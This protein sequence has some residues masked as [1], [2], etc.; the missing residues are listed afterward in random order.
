MDG[1]LGQRKAKVDSKRRLVM[2]LE[3]R[4][5]LGA[6]KRVVVA[7]HPDGCLLLF[8]MDYWRQTVR[9]A[10]ERPSFLNDDA[11]AFRRLFLGN[12]GD[13]PLDKVGRLR[14]PDNLLMSAGIKE[15][16]VFVGHGRYIEVWSAERWEE[17]SSKEEQRYRELWQKFAVLDGE[18]EE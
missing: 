3:F 8:P 10:V 14:L 5:L 2:P 18:R 11:T 12:A 4:E 15:E 16:A 9:R 7:K 17:N 6:E 1:F 13:L